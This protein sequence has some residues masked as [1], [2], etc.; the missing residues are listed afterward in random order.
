V[1][2]SAEVSYSVDGRDR[3][4]AVNDGWNAFAIEN[5]AP[6]LT[7]PGIIGQVLWTHVTDDTTRE[8][9]GALMDD[10]RAGRGPTAFQ[11]RCDGPRVRRLLRLSIEAEGTGRLVLRTTLLLADPRAAVP[12]LDAEVAR[13]LEVVE[14][15]AWCARVRTLGGA[16]AD[17]ETAAVRDAIFI[18]SPLPRLRHV[19]CDACRA[20]LRSPRSA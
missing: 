19:T 17:V 8:L 10:V 14:V 1:S 12:L 4:V 18:R 9:Y 2:T 5:D 3:I 15:C 6:H 11:V 20:D 7:A 13:S 16:W